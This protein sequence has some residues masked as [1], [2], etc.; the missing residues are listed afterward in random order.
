MLAGSTPF[1]YRAIEYKHENEIISQVKIEMAGMGTRRVRLANPPPEILDEAVRFAFSN[2]DEIDSIEM[3][4]GTPSFGRK[5]H[6]DFTN[7]FNKVH[8]VPHDDS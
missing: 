7:C 2:Y 3:V 6:Q 1:N 8:S 5:R 4:Q